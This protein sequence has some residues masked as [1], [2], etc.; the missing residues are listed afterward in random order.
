MNKKTVEYRDFINFDTLPS[1]WC[2]GCGNGLIFKAMA[3]A[4]AELGFSFSNT[5]VVSGIGCTARM[6]G[7]FNLDSINAIHGRA[8]PIAEGI[9]RVQPQVHVVV[10]SGDGDIASIGGNHLIHSSRRNIAITVIMNDNQIYGL[11][12]GQASPTTPHGQKTL[13]TP[14]GNPFPPVNVQGIVT[15]Q[16]HYFFG[17]SCVAFFPHLKETIKRALQWSG[18]SLVQVHSDCIENNGRRLGFKSAWDMLQS[19]KTMYTIV[20]QPKNQLAPHELGVITSEEKK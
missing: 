9:K 15:S 11:T 10:I 4:F 20:P 5:V 2:P 7:Y 17:R 13:S 19:F 3:M 16:Q 8:L 12:G 14:L 6:A 18:F 1:I